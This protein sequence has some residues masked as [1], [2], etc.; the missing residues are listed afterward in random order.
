MNL[1]EHRVETEKALAA[2]EKFH[3]DVKGHRVLVEPMA[4][5]E[6]SGLIK[7]N[8]DTQK[9]DRLAVT[10]G[11]VLQIG[12]LCWKDLGDVPPWCKVGD[13]V[14][15]QRYGGARVHDPV[16]NEFRE[17]VALINDQDIQAVITRYNEYKEEYNKVKEEGIAIMRT[18]RNA[19]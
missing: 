12:D 7:L 8:A 6:F 15:F 3:I 13:L 11:T 14:L 17:D 19:I 4:V 1:N 2:V 10:L 18:Q 5:A 9:S 16:P